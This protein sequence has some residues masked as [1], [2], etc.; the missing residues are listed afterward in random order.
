MNFGAI[1]DQYF[2]NLR[3]HNGSFTGWAGTTARG[4]VGLLGLE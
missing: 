1:F 2:A 4:G 3:W